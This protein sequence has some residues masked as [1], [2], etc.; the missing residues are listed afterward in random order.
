MRDVKRYLRQVKS[1]LP[2]RKKIIDEIKSNLLSFC[3]ETSNSDYPSIVER[4]GTPQQIAAAYVDEQDTVTLLEDLRIKHKIMKWVSFVL[5]I[6]LATW[7]GVVV[8]VAVKG[9]V[10]VTGELQYS[11]IEVISDTGKEN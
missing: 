9:A 5:A 11:E 3:V 6:I 1:W 8:Y 2:C 7:I 10:N 4:F